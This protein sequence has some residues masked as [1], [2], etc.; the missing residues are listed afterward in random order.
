VVNYKQLRRN[1]R[2]FLA[3][4]GLTDKEF[5]VLLP[6]FQEAYERAQ[7]MNQTQS[8]RKRKRQVG[9]GR[10][11]MLATMEDKLLFS[12]MYQK[13]YPL[14]ELLAVTF[15]MS[16]AGVNHWVH[17]LL[18]ILKTAL[19]DLGMMP[20]RDGSAFAQHEQ[21]QGEA[22]DL[23]IDGTER[24]RQRPKNPEKQALH[25]SGKK[26]IHADKNL[27]IVN[28]KQQ[29]IGYLSPTYGGQI[30]DKKL[31]DNEAIVY[32]AKTRLHKDTGFQGYEP[33]VKQTLQPKKTSHH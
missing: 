18:P 4:T 23:I 1:K 26:K 7:P 28:A 17:R 9:G 15:G 27:V 29:R 5:K 30:H 25:Y 24:R 13:S 19:E 14:Q 32:P 20:E 8:G 3:L 11:A 16:Q 2:R 10:K 31:A 21:A 12:L 6:S 22:L 33:K